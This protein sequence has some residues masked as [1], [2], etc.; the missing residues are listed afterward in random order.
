MQEYSY[1]NLTQ[2]LSNWHLNNK[3]FDML[4]LMAQLSKLFSESEVPYLDYRLAENLF[5][6]YYQAKNDARSCTAYDARLMRLG[7]GIKTFILNQDGKHS[8][9]KIAEFNRLK[10]T[11]NPLSGIDLAKKLAQYRN[12]RIQFA[13]N[14]YD[15][16]ETQYHIVGRIE[17]G[18]RLFNTPYEEIDTNHIHLVKDNDTSCSFHDEINEYTFNK[19]KSV[20]MKRFTVP[21]NH[22]DINVAIL[23]DPLSL[24]EQ[25]FSENASEISI[26]KKLRKGTD[27]VILPLYSIS[28]KKGYFVPEKSGLN[29][30][31]AG[32]RARNEYE[33]YI[34]VPS[35]IQN[36]YPNFFPP[37]N[38]SFSLIL[39]DG[40][41][42]SAKICQDG[43]KALMSNPNRDLG[44]WI[45]HKV[46]N[47]RPWE[48][49]TMEDLDRLGFNSVCVEKLN[50]TDDQ[51]NAVYRISFSDYLGNYESFINEN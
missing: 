13:N 7:I 24:L 12:E 33:V 20:L 30:F 31:N 45:L 26:A 8:I 48:I 42:L 22:I 46:L 10:K 40:K 43:G 39:P 41:V 4:R 15:V 3:Y 35:L 36:N 47:K 28:K 25:F 23:D 38:Q 1:N 49:V 27:Y 44:E 2:F 51:G 50:R 9:E 34:P 37:R 29:Q 16:N 5:C 11:L 14:Q 6:K 19:S 18:L 32:G 17:G 21:K